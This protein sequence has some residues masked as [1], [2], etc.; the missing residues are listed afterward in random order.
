MLPDT[1]RVCSLRDSNN[2]E[3]NRNPAPRTAATN[4][5]IA[6][7][8]KLTT[9]VVS[10]SFVPSLIGNITAYPRDLPTPAQSEP[11]ANSR[12]FRSSAVPPR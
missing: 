5:G 10:R 12:A 1:V 3:E 8:L 4:T 7:R 2:I 6:K 9:Q 11:L